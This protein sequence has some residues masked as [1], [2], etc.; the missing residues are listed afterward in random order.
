MNPRVRIS[1]SLFILVLF[2]IVGLILLRPTRF[3]KADTPPPAC[4]VLNNGNWRNPDVWNCH[5]SYPG[6]NDD[7]VI[8][9]GDYTVSID[10]DEIVKGIVISA[11]NLNI[12]SHSLTVG[13]DGISIMGAGN[14]NASG[15]SLD[16]NG[17]FLQT[18]GSFTAPTSSF[19]VSGDFGLSAGIFTKGG[20]LTFDGSTATT[21]EDLNTTK[22]NL[23]VVTISGTAV[24][25]LSGMKVDTVNVSGTLNLGSS[26]YILELANIGATA[27]ILTVSGT[28][29]PGTN[30]TVKYTAT[31]SN[32]NVNVTTTTYNNLQFAP[33][34]AES[35]NMT[36]SLTNGNA[37]TGSLTIDANAT[38]NTYIAPDSYDISCVNVTVNTGGAIYAGAARSSGTSYFTVLGSWIINNTTSGFTYGK[39]TVDLIGTGNVK[40]WNVDGCGFYNLKA[41]AANQ[42]TTKT[43]NALLVFNVLTLG[44]GTYKDASGGSTALGNNISSVATPLVTAGA[45]I[46]GAPITYGGYTTTNITKTTYGVLNIRLYGDPST[47]TANFAGDITATT[48]TIASSTSQTVTVNSAGYNLNCSSLVIGVSGQTQNGVLNM[49]S[50]TLTDTGDL[51]IYPLIGANHNILSFTSGAANIAGSLTNSDTITAGSATINVSG[52]MTNNTGAVISANTSTW[53][54]GDDIGTDSWTNSGTFTYNTSTVNL[55]GTGNVSGGEDFYDLHAAATGKTTTV[56]SGS[57]IYINNVLTMGGVGGRWESAIGAMDIRLR[58]N[59]TP[60]VN[61]GATFAGNIT[62]RYESSAD[63]NVAS[64]TYGYLWIE[65]LT[66]N[67]TFTATGDITVGSNFAVMEVPQGKRTIF[68]TSGYKMTFASLSIGGVASVWGAATLKA[69]GSGTINVNGDVALIYDSDSE[70][71]LDSSTFSGNFYIGGN[72]TNNS[73]TFLAG[74]STINF[75][76]STGTQT[77]NSGGVGTGKSFNNLIHS[78]TGKLQLTGSALDVDGN[79]TNS[80]GTFDANGQNQNFAGNFSLSDNTFYTK[81]GTLTFDGTN[82]LTDSN[83]TTKQNLGTVIVDGTVNLGSADQFDTLT[84]NGTL[85]TYVAPNSYDISCVNVTVNTS[86]V[87]Y[88]GTNDAEGTST[89]T[90]SK[91][92][93]NAGTFTRGK[94]TVNLTGTGTFTPGGTYYNLN[95]ATNGEKTTVSNNAFTINGVLKLGN[96]SSTFESPQ[97]VYLT[98]SGAPLVTGGATITV[99][100][101]VYN[102]YPTHITATTYNS[103]LGL[104]CTNCV[105]DGNITALATIVASN[106]SGGTATVDTNGYNITA[107]TLSIG[108]GTSYYGVLKN[109]SGSVSTITTSSDVTVAV[110]T[111]SNKNKLLADNMNISAAGNWANNDVFTAGNATVNFTK[112]TGPQ[113]LNSGGV[114]TGKAF[115]NLTHSGAGTLQ[116]DFNNLNVDGDFQNSAGT[117]N[118]NNW[119]MTVAGDWDSTSG[120][121][122]SGTKTITLDGSGVQSIIS[123]GADTDHYFYN[124]TVTNTSTEGITFADS[125]SL[126]DGGTFTDNAA[127]SKL[128]FT[129]GQTYTFPNINLS[130]ASGNLITLRSSLENNPWKLNVS[131]ANPTVSYV[132]VKDSDASF[133]QAIT[134]ID[135]EDSG[136]NVNWLFGQDIT[137][138][139]N[140][141]NLSATVSGQDIILAWQ[142]PSDADFNGVKIQHSTS[143]YPSSPDVGTNIFSGLATTYTDKSLELNKRYY[144]TVFTYDA[145]GNYSSGA[146]VSAIILEESETP[147]SPE[148][149]QPQPTEQPPTPKA[150]TS[151][152]PKTTTGQIN[153]NEEIK[154]NHPLAKEEMSTEDIQI[155]AQTGKNFVEIAKS[156]QYHFFPGQ[157]I[158]I[159][160]PVDK[161]PKSTKTIILNLGQ[162]YYLLKLNQGYYETIVKVPEVKDN[163]KLVFNIVYADDTLGMLTIAISVDPFGYVCRKNIN[164]WNKLL[165]H[166]DYEELRITKATISL[167]IYDE[168]QGKWIL[169]SD[170]KNPQDNPKLTNQSGEYSF[171]VSP[172]KYYL[173][174]RKAGHRSVRTK[175]F[176]VTNYE[177]NQNIEM[178]PYLS[179]YIIYI[180]IAI[181]LFGGFGFVIFIHRRS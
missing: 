6:E 69:T 101:F 41:A 40:S 173:E 134:P 100:S 93:A 22:Q 44:T 135:S 50:G 102:T 51:T 152:K 110:P 80:A 70:N 59:G 52:S 65:G 45:D 126:A 38:F 84:I 164:L 122:I 61:T 131:Q 88:A 116:L 161:L 68:D 30:S 83:T 172:G 121:F 158:T 14:L 174:A 139:S 33:T 145:A 108:G 154:Q 78:G 155:F 167:Y 16:I 27:T 104:K 77:L 81:G 72:W 117:F 82:T 99:Q 153:I 175:E 180:I 125:V 74:T 48:V 19:T 29:N 136:H 5:G 178:T 103:P 71:I 146:I 63:S 10:N 129:Q 179:N 20:A 157:E 128:T 166:R 1:V 34:S 140:I 115:N 181:V 58:G 106:S 163:Y 148:T 159:R 42:T 15:G 138:P 90:A 92:W 55:K 57:S 64:G 26:G 147:P 156:S 39:S 86:G 53:N 119:D 62:V 91:S 96:S 21:F 132:D 133:G 67:V 43:S 7:V 8:D 130:G 137:P 54:V 165:G 25:L 76:K 109:T 141:S 123:G 37:M 112:A 107:T 87:L 120:K 47:Q 169:W 17:N 127:G 171:Y 85:N 150:P 66:N 142:N 79:F 118:T 56:T 4:T 28:L 98:G 113:T 143:D 149:E 35:Y 168:K 124:L 60:Y 49:G 12:T 31:N 94:S 24:T 95:A 170:Q 105:L 36:D 32:D 160:L 46:T 13:Q 18:N 114:G 3:F 177:V 23:G 89:I 111:V 11:G 73:E 9:S 97:I 2:S 176:E 162:S 151:T 144:Y 75:T